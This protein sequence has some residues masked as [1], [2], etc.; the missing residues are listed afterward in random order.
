ML[1]RVTIPELAERFGLTPSSES[2]SLDATETPVANNEAVNDTVEPPALV[3]VSGPVSEEIRAVTE[4]FITPEATEAYKKTY[5][6]EHGEEAW[7]QN[8]ETYVRTYLPLHSNE[9][10]LSNWFS[11]GEEG[12]AGDIYGHIVESGMTVSQFNAL[13]DG[14]ARELRNYLKQYNIPIADFRELQT[15]LYE[16]GMDGHVLITDGMTILGVLEGAFV[17]RMESLNVRQK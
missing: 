4:M 3:P 14:S 9:G 2:E 1:G 6:L 5:V 13:R 11:A 15:M 7:K 8:F 12:P 10:W 16:I 17:F